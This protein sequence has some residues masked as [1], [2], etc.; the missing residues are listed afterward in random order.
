MK[1]RR[2]Q[3]TIQQWCKKAEKLKKHKIVK[4]KP[5]NLSFVVSSQ[6]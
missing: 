1:G 6:Q 4:R 5:K 2:Y 3:Q